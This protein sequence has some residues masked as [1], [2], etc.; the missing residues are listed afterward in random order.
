MSRVNFIVAV[1]ELWLAYGGPEE[2]GWWYD[3]GGLIRIHKMFNSEKDAYAA[4]R[5]L[6]RGLEYKREVMRD[7]RHPLSSTAYS[8]GHLQARVY[9]HHAPKDWPEARPHYE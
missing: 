1:Y 7:Y 2:G 8:G 5:R 9:M 6:N 3:T 4:C